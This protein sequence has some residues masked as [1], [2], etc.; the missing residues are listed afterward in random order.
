MAIHANPTKTGLQSPTMPLTFGGNALLGSQAG[1]MLNVSSDATSSYICAGIVRS[2][3]A[4]YHGYH[5]ELND[6][7][8][9]FCTPPDFGAGV[10]YGLGSVCC[11][12][13][14]PGTRVVVE[15]SRAVGIIGTILC[16]CNNQVVKDKGAGPQER[17]K[18]DEATSANASLEKPYS[19]DKKGVPVPSVGAYRPVDMYPGDWA[20]MNE[21]GSGFFLGRTRLSLRGSNLSRIDL[22]P[23]DDVFRVA[24]GY[25]QV[26]THEG[27]ELLF[28]DNGGFVSHERLF[29]PYVWETA[30]CKDSSEFDS[31]LKMPKEPDEVPE[32]IENP[33]FAR[34][35][36]ISGS[37]AGGRQIFVSHP[38][39]DKKVNK[40][41]AHV[42]LSDSGALVFR[43]TS[44]IIFSQTEKIDVPVRIRAPEDK[45]GVDVPEVE[46]KDEQSPDEGW[47]KN[48][49]ARR[50]VANI[51][52]Q[53][54]KRF[55][56]NVK[57][58]RLDSEKP[59]EDYD[60][61][62]GSKADIGSKGKAM[63]VL[64][65]D[66]S[67]TLCTSKGAE[68]RLDGEDITISCPGRLSFRSGKEIDVLSSGDF[69]V[70]AKND[71]EI[72]GK[73]NVLVS[74]QGRTA[75]YADKSVFLEAGNAEKSSSGFTTSRGSDSPGVYIVS[76]KK[77]NPVVID[78]ETIYVH[79]HKFL[80]VM[81]V[82]ENGE[83]PHN[84]IALIGM[85]ALYANAYNV[86]ITSGKSQDAGAGLALGRDSGYLFGKS[87]GVAGG[88]SAFL[89][90]ASLMAMMMP[91]GSDIYSGMSS[92]YT[93]VREHSMFQ[94]YD[95]LSNIPHFSYKKYDIDEIEESEWVNI[96]QGASSW[97]EEK[98]VNQ[99]LP[100][101]GEGKKVK[102]F[103]KDLSKVVDDDAA[104]G[105]KEEQQKDKPNEKTVEFKDYKG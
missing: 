41:L 4:N 8:S 95:F 27:K 66:G 59:S 97:G 99:T 69:I 32:E 22:F 34:Y 52:S 6:G 14:M 62:A 23:I 78:A 75:L 91:G 70:K 49:A 74:S 30:G 20:I 47:W 60:E 36:E 100:W 54:Y 39:F 104:L 42:A 93:T 71:I 37:I 84:A 1:R 58:W 11:P 38:D 82:D 19:D 102:T 101:P 63:L 57:D 21:F 103:R 46:G 35:R 64:G 28:A 26:F 87:A 80:G 12:I 15:L 25:L 72:T 55:K 68:I 90:S 2:S 13:I 10:F 5:V 94:P 40:G 96:K 48:S 86:A 17:L 89:M 50:T 81:A 61:H 92:G 29:S 65:K 53:L 44:D 88:R 24:A 33:D 83:T 76:P 7:T 73:D 105:D 51:V 98:K 43:S 67:I 3:V 31:K 85:G 18:V 45:E 56:K 79:P 9:V 16:I 77:E